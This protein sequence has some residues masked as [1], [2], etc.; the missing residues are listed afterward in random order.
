MLSVYA[1]LTYPWQTLEPEERLAALNAAIAAGSEAAEDDHRGNTAPLTGIPD[2]E[3]YALA[4][5][6]AD[7]GAPDAGMPELHEGD[8]RFQ[9]FRVAYTATI[10]RRAQPVLC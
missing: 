7:D 3:R 8:L 9:A 2:M 1:A 5:P 4:I 10:A 6:L